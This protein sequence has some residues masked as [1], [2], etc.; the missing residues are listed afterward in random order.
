MQARP[1]HT[2]P[3]R[4]VLD[5]WGVA[6]AAPLPGG[7]GTAYG[8]DDL[9]LKPVGDPHEAEWLA[10]TLYGLPRSSELRIIRPVP[11]R[12][13]AWVFAGWS[14]WERLVGTP[15]PERW[16]DAL[17]VSGRFHA[18]VADVARSDAIG[19]HRPWAQG[20]AF[21]WAEHELV[22]PAVLAV[23]VNGLLVRRVPT[24]LPLQLVHGDLCGNI[25]FDEDAAPAVIDVS[26][27][28]RPRRYADAILV[29]DAMAWH[30]AAEDALETFDDPIGVQMLVRA[31]LFRLGTASVSFAD[32]ASR[33][34]KEL[35][36]YGPVLQA[37]S[38][39]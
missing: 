9:V 16:R 15:A 1:Q 34:R 38:R 18:E 14:A 39:R 2:P 20:D 3:L 21:A 30:G 24:D 26:P 11:T 25:L 37:V 28:W 23:A 35:L 33:L 6:E 13:G 8:T 10:K 4:E 17:E 36:A 7:Q 29:I 27:Y 22:V 32:H 5:A 19:R 12:D 31:L